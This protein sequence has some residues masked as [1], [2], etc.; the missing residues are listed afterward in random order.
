MTRTY[1]RVLTY[2]VGKT[3]H[4]V[5]CMAA[6]AS[7][8]WSALCPVHEMRRCRTGHVNGRSVKAHERRRY[9]EPVGR[10]L[11]K[12]LTST[13]VQTALSLAGDLLTFRARQEF[14]TQLDTQAEMASL[15]DAGVTPRQLL[16][17]IGEVWMLNAFDARFHDERELQVAMASA[18]LKLKARSGRVRTYPLARTK[19]FLGNELLE[20]F[21]KFLAGVSMKIEQDTETRKVAQ[22]AFEQWTLSGE[23]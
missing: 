18:V 1:A 23:S 21:G 16:Q 6:P 19:M 17:A 14:T 8:P 11:A 12:Y 20:T 2:V 13:A 7:L 10:T 4:A 9:S 3:S 22:K 5:G 15:L